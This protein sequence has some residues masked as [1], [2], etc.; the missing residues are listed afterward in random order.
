[1]ADRNS[2]LGHGAAF[3]AYAIFGFNIIVCKDLTGGGLIPPLGIFTLRSLIAGSLFWILS[4]FICRTRIPDH[5]CDIHNIFPNSRSPETQQTY[6][7]QHVQLCSAD[8]CHR[9]QHHDWNGHP[10]MA[11]GT[12]YSNGIC[13][14]HF[15]QSQPVCKSDIICPL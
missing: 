1:M 8:N 4:L 15:R 9:C 7:R 10:H 14:T 13:R 5:L 6:N 2:I 11:E 3:I 12:C